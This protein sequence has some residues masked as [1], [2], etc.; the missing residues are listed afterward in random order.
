MARVT[1]KSLQNEVEM[2]RT[3]CNRIETELESAKAQL[4]SR[5]TRA[6]VEPEVERILLLQ[7]RGMPRFYQFGR[8]VLPSARQ[9]AYYESKLGG[10]H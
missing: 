10:T 3:H 8:E 2:L 4:A 6:N 9:L 7:Q 5:A 1:I